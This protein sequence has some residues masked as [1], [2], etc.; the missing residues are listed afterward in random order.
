M[1]EYFNRNQ[2]R[3]FKLNI[4]GLTALADQAC[5]E[6]VIVNRTGGSITIYDQGYSDEA[7]SFLLADLESATFRGITN[8]LQ[9][10]ASG[11]GDIYYRT[12]FYSNTPSA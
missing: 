1:A 3:S 6:V 2:C 11:S 10:S 4:S 7:N 8:T 12:Q 9:V 5:S